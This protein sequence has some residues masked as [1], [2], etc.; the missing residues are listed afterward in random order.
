[1]AEVTYNAYQFG[2][3]LA[4]QDPFPVFEPNFGDQDYD[5]GLADDGWPIPPPCI[6]CGV[7]YGACVH[8]Q[9]QPTLF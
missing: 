3:F 8:D 5:Y 9:L 6:V 1:M 4:D 7:L 2:L